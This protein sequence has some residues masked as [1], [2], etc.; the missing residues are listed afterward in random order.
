[1]EETLELTPAKPATWIL[2]GLLLLLAVLACS[3]AVIMIKASTEH[4][5]LV[6]SYRLLLAAVILMPF[7]VRDVRRA[8]A[9]DPQAYT[10]RQVG[11]SLIPAVG[12]AV[13][14]MTWVVGARMTQVSNAS[15]L[16]NMAP[17]ALPFFLYLFYRERVTRAE[18]IGT[19][20][21]FAGVILLTGANVRLDIT[22]FLGDLICLGSMLAF[23]CYLALG[24]RNSARISLWLYM[25]PL[26]YMA[27]ILCLLAALFFINPI[28]AY[29][30][31]NVLYIV[32]LAVIPT[33]IGHT[34]LNYSMKHFRG[35]VVGIANLGQVIFAGMM[36]AAFF[37]EIPSAI[38]YV[39]AALILAGIF[40]GILGNKR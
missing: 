8:R 2:N 35:Q 19:L 27:G 32:G 14:F 17:L 28:K 9:I 16:V 7:F 1:M 38:Y 4:P 34:L 21:A 26:Y 30:L 10:L 36:A 39:A 29:T 5:L 18:V 40:I 3:T 24:R 15:L 13:H 6:A 22:R 37:N 12:L 23:V 33:V 11:W 20:C 31:P 25:V